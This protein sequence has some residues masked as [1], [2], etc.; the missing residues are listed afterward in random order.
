MR[1]FGFGNS[2]RRRTQNLRS[3]LIFSVAVG[4]IAS[5]MAYSIP[6]AASSALPAGTVYFAEAPGQAPSYIFPM[7]PPS[8][9]TPANVLQFQY[10]MFRPLYWFGNGG[11]SSID[12]PLSLAAPPV[13]S[14]GN[15]TVTITMG[16]YLWS[17]G[18]QVD[19]QDVIFWMNLLKADKTAWS[20]YVPG[21]FPDNVISYT[22]TGDKTVVMK[23][24]NSYN[25]TWFTYNELSQIVPL[26]LAWD[27]T[28]VTQTPPTAATPVAS[29]PDQSTA[30]AQAVYHF[31]ASEATVRSTYATSPLWSDVDGPFKLLSFN[32]AGKAIFIPNPSY[33]GPVKAQISE[34]V[35]LPFS[36]AFA[37]ESSLLRPNGVNF[38]FLPLSDLSQATRLTK[39]GFHIVPWNVSEFSPLYT[40]FTSAAGPLLQ[41]VYLRQ[42]LQGVIDRT[43]LLSSVLRGDGTVTAAQ[44]PLAPKGAF[45]SSVPSP[46]PS[47][48][49]LAQARRDLLAHGWTITTSSG[50]TCKSPGTT[51]TECGVGIGDG[52][53]LT[54][55][56]A[57][58][59][60]DPTTTRELRSLMTGMKKLG[61]KLT[62]QPL[63]PTSIQQSITGCGSTCSWQLFDPGAGYL[64]APD[65]LP[66]AQSVLETGGQL[67][68]GHASISTIDIA[69]RALML[70][71]NASTSLG[72]LTLAVEQQL[73]LLFLP[74]PS[75]QIS[76][77]SNHL[78]NLGL[79]QG[80]YGTL[81]PENLQV[82]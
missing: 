54:L 49:T 55:S 27:R 70:A 8:Q 72:A 22:A 47:S 11:G 78:H 1:S 15:R 31:L 39:A 69:E 68:I 66:S 77:V 17:D 33:G 74:N 18:Q 26:P 2:L 37:E 79:V 65:H 28:A 45:T 58:P 50:A 42:I 41:Q 61:I 32:R 53:P 23:L 20:P 63:S 36:S 48:Q 25:P 6:T 7:V 51:A 71:S 59:N 16:N 64:Y 21:Q 19:A 9:F 4:I 62:L 76:V 80:A 5:G 60:S 57:Y 10:L 56:L 3:V 14:N 73:P 81:N 30:G 12:Y 38:G 13:Y 44:L 82:S 35:E 75:Y 67:N 43:P 52:Q 46:D 34:F 40:N 29:L 24:D